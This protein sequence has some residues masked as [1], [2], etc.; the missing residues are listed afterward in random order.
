MYFAF[1]KVEGCDCIIRSF[2]VTVASI[3]YA[4]GSPYNIILVAGSTPKVDFL[5]ITTNITLKSY[6]P[7]SGTL[8]SKLN[9]PF[10]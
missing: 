10:R 5:E 1:R 9:D 2:H 8:E 4:S 7:V 6:K 3:N